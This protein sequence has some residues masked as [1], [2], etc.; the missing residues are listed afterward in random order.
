MSDDELA[1]GTEQRLRVHALFRLPVLDGVIPDVAKVELLKAL[2]VTEVYHDTEDLRLFRSGVTLRRIEGGPDEGW[3]LSLPAEG[4]SQGEELRLPLAAGEIGRVPDEFAD[5]VT[6]LVR[7]AELTPVATL[8]VERTPHQL[9]DADSER[10]V[11]LVDDT[12]SILDGEHVAARFRELSVL[13]VGSGGDEVLGSVVEALVEHGAVPGAGSRAVG[14]LGPR[15]SAP[16]DV[17]LRPSACPSD[18]AA[19]AVRAH[20]ALQVSRFLIQD[21]RVRRDLP[22]SVHQLRVAA[23]RLRSGLKV[24]KDLLDPEWADQL[25]AELGWAAG[26]LGRVRDTEVM[27][28]RLEE[29][30]DELPPRYSQL[31]TETVERVLKAELA[32]AKADALASLRSPRHV[33]LLVALVDAVHHPRLTEMA[34]EPC[35]AVLPPRVEKSFKR[36]AKDVREL[37]V[38]SSAHPWHE[39]RIAAKK[40]RYAA[41]LVTPVFGEPAKRLAKALSEVTEIL[42]DHQ[43]CYVAQEELRHIAAMPETDGSSGFALGLLHAAEEE[44]EMALRDDFVKLWPQVRHVYKKTSLL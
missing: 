40:A 18:P 34:Y 13:S 36:L 10:V 30:A 2:T 29:H 7:E 15:A 12:V 24:F 38:D 25:R 32:K 22:D 27:L 16:P 6:G 39:T 41:E 42:G 14:A 23:R 33:E 19:D 44:R 20:I 26:E 8:R 1:G 31:A 43:D 37:H 28:A 17:V 21:R 3:E 4:G 9:L 5:L 11:E 35:E